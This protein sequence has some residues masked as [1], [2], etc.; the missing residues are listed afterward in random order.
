MTEPQLV[1]G[2]LV[3]LLLVR[4]GHQAALVVGAPPLVIDGHETITLEVGNRDERLVD[5]ELLVVDTETVA[6]SIRVR[7]QTRLEDW[8]GGGLDTRNEVRRGE[9]SLW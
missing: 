6:M 8:I 2:L 9:R 7:E 4:E 1:L 5:G 3:R